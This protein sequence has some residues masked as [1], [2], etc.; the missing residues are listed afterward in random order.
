MLDIPMD[1]LNIDYQMN[2]QNDRVNTRVKHLD[3]L[4]ILL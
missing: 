3:V 4:Q 2:D 1:K